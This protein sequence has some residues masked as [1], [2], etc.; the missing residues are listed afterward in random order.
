MPSFTIIAVTRKMSL[1]NGL[2]MRGDFSSGLLWC[3]SLM[4]RLSAPLCY[5]FLLLP[6]VSVTAVS[7]GVLQQVKQRMCV[8][9]GGSQISATGQTRF[10]QPRM[11][12]LGLRGLHTGLVPRCP[13]CCT[14]R[15]P[16]F[17]ATYPRPQAEVPP[18]KTAFDA[19]HSAWISRWSA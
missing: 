3:A 7:A 18:K 6:G 19:D 8:N 4:A 17:S 12:Y 15:V 11:I 13:I 2:E 1:I 5:H 9:S 14:C 16:Q 10:M